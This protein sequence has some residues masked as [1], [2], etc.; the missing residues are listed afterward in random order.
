MARDTP[1]NQGTAQRE[2]SLLRVERKSAPNLS[3]YEELRGS[4]LVQEDRI[5]SI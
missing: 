4:Q 5:S 2:L 1:P 3:A